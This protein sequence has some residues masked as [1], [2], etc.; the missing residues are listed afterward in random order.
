MKRLFVWIAFFAGIILVWDGVVRFGLV[1]PAALARPW[2]TF[3]AIPHLFFPS[4]NLPDVTSTF[5]RSVVA[6]LLS[7]PCG[8]VAGIICFYAGSARAPGEFTIDFLRSIP[9]T[10][11]V[12][13]FLIIF[14]IGD[15]AKIAAATFSSALA[16]ALAVIVGLRGRNLTRLGVARI[17]GLTGLKRVLLLDLPEAAP[18][19]FLGLRTGISLALI[20]VIVAEMLIG[21]NH[22]IGKVIADMRYTDDKPRMY[23]AIIIA[24]VIG[25]LYNLI[26]GRIERIIHWRGYQ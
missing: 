17:L 15:S 14:G 18:Q 4:E 5:S 9:A 22:G 24:G 3:L 25:Y 13:M 23:A 7:I 1:S 10:A 11:L 20:L 21:S 2:E 8:V 19:I 16:I 6:F 26:L 12:P